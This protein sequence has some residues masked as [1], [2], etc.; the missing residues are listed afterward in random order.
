[1]GQRA[2]S[3]LRSQD[4]PRSHPPAL[5]WPTAGTGSRVF[6]RGQQEDYGDCYLLASQWRKAAL[7][8]CRPSRHLAFSIMGTS[9][10]RGQSL[11]A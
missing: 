6:L 3:H 5:R 10:K 9:G 4:S 1:M 2:E 7:C 8:S 11:V